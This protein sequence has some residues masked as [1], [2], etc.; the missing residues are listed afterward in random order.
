[1]PHTFDRHSRATSASGMADVAEEFFDAPEVLGDEPFT[2]AATE[3]QE[4]A[5]ERDPHADAEKREQEGAADE[6]DEAIETIHGGLR[7]QEEP[8]PERCYEVRPTSWVRSCKSLGGIS[9][10]FAWQIPMCVSSAR[11]AA[12]RLVQLRARRWCFGFPPWTKEGAREAVAGTYGSGSH[13]HAQGAALHHQATLA[14]LS[15][16][17]AFPRERGRRQERVEEAEA[18]KTQGNRL[19]AEAA[20][21]QAAALYSDAIAA[22]PDGY[23]VGLA[24]FHG[25]R[26]ACHM[27]LVRW[28]R[29]QHANPN[30]PLVYQG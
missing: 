20:Y 4:P 19:F 9:G 12:P 25:N 7:E 28:G 2:R 14:Q 11:V 1:M 18:L 6:E 26:A 13:H 5:F 22:A 16:R 3:C 8:A 29:T 17:R 23:A 10:P 30:T 24:A 21:D 15:V 27:C